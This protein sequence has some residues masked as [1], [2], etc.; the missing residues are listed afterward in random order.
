VKSF[1]KIAAIATMFVMLASTSVSAHAH[2]GGGDHYRPPGVRCY[3]TCTAHTIF[4]PS[5]APVEITHHCEC[6]ASKKD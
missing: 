3:G 4:F 1:R 2:F 6:G 5:N